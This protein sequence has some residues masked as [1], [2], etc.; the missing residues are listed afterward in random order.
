MPKGNRGSP[1]PRQATLVNDAA[2]MRVAQISAPRDDVD[3]PGCELDAGACGVLSDCAAVRLLPGRLV[4]QDRDVAVHALALI[5]F[6]GR[7][8]N[9]RRVPMKRHRPPPGSVLASCG[10][11]TRGSHLQDGLDHPGFWAQPLAEQDGGVVETTAM[12]VQRVGW[13]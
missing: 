7:N 12:G 1:A 6:V 13:N 3:V 2:S 11:K 9:L 4:F 5:E 8:Q 10:P